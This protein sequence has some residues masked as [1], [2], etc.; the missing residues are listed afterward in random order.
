M[1]AYYFN[2]QANYAPRKIYVGIS[3]L[4]VFILHTLDLTN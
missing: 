3:I 2:D 1:T 4:K